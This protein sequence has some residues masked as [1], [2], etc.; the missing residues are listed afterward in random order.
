MVLL[1]VLQGGP[2]IEEDDL[3]T[4]PMSWVNRGRAVNRE[5]LSPARASAGR[6]RIFTQNWQFSVRGL[7][8]IQG[9]HIESKQIFAI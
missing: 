2:R 1:W 4:I 9:C 5:V 7:Q 6:G 8:I 3:P